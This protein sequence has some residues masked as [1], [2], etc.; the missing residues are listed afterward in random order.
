MN[1]NL[2]IK[3]KQEQEEKN[4][5]DKKKDKIDVD[6]ACPIYFPYIINYMQETYIDHPI[7]FC[8]TNEKQS[9]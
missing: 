5:K 6:H 3:L 9:N 7:R 4:E 8:V 1:K 2:N